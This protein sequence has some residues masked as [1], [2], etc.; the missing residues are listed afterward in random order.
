MSMFTAGLCLQLKKKK[1]KTNPDTLISSFVVEICERWKGALVHIR[2]HVLEKKRACSIKMPS[3]YSKPLK[4]GTLSSLQRDDLSLQGVAPITFCQWQLFI[5]NLQNT[6]EVTY[7]RN[8]V[9]YTDLWG[10]RYT[11]KTCWHTEDIM[12]N[13][14]KRS[15]LSHSEH[16]V[17]TSCCLRMFPTFKYYGGS[18]KD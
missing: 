13:R 3:H 18:E 11:G 5:P 4:S 10:L 1:K 15:F 6:N 17:C 9:I 16:L 8:I 12:K 7:R 2:I 14:T